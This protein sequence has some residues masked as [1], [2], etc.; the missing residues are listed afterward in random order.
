MLPLRL[1]LEGFLSYRDRT[2]FDFQGARLWML[3]GANGAGKSTVFDALRFALYGTHRAGK[4]NA[5]SLVH[6]ESQKL[7]VEADLQIGENVFRLVRTV[8][9]NTARATWQVRQK[10]ADN[11]EDVPETAMKSDYERWIAANI[12]LS[13]EAF[14]A[15]VYLSQGKSDAILNPDP[16][17][18]F[19]LLSQLVDLRVYEGWHA[20][21]LEKRVASRAAWTEARRRWEL[22]PLP[23][24]DELEQ[25]RAKASEQATLA[26]QL[27]TRARELELLQNDAL[28]WTNWRDARAKLLDSAAT[29]RALLGDEATIER[30]FA[31]LQMLE[32]LG[33]TLQ[34]FVSLAEGAGELR[35]QISDGRAQSGEAEEGFTRAQTAHEQARDAASQEDNRARKT[36]ESAMTL[37]L[38]RAQLAP[39]EDELGRWQTLRDE[40]GALSQSLA[41]LSE[42]DTS[43]GAIASL[44]SARDEAQGAARALPV[45]RRFAQSRARL[46]EA[47][48][49]LLQIARRAD[50]LD[51]QITQAKTRRAEA[52]RALA[53]AELGFERAREN[54]AKAQARFDAART[55]KSD[56][57]RVEGEARCHFCGQELSPEHAHAE[58]TRLQSEWEQAQEELKRAQVED[59]TA[60]FART[61]AQ[62]GVT[63]ASEAIANLERESVSSNS[64][65]TLHVGRRDDALVSARGAWDELAQTRRA[66]W[67]S[68]SFETSLESPRP[69]ASDFETWEELA[70]SL[71][72]RE[73]ALSKAAQMQSEAARLQLE[74]A[75][76]ERDLAPLHA[77][78]N[79]D[80]ERQWRARWNVVA[81]ELVAARIERDMGHSD[82]QVRERALKA[83]VTSLSLARTKRDG[84]AAK[85][86]PLAGE[87]AALHRQLGGLW[88][89]IREA[90]RTAGDSEDESEIPLLKQAGLAPSSNRVSLSGLEEG[91]SPATSMAVF[92]KHVLVPIE[93]P[94]EREFDAADSALL[95]GLRACAA[96]WRQE[97]ARLRE[98]NIAARHEALSQAREALGRIEGEVAF[99]SRAMDEVP[100][101]AKCSPQE[102]ERERTQTRQALEDATQRERES[103][104]RAARLGQQSEERAHLENEMFEREREFK[105]WEELELL[106]GP[107]QLQRHLLCEAERGI[108]R[109]ANAVLEAIS[110][111]S[112]RL[113]TRVESDEAGA[114][115]PQVLDVLCTH[116]SGGSAS[117]PISPAFL[118]GSQRFR[119]AVALALGIGRTAA[120]GV[121]A[122][123]NG[124]ARAETILIDEGFG[125]LDQAG[126]DEMRDELRAL[127]RELGRII[128]VSHQEDFA[129]GFPARFDISMEA[130][131]SRARRLVQ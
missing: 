34:S 40:R 74:I 37:E 8:G 16:E 86:G 27:A 5:E 71:P 50:E 130:G 62:D 93:F 111:G 28:R 117:P 25:A 49:G 102:L 31:R 14:C 129:A 103:R 75:R 54:Q 104:E 106:L 113:E 9:R 59:A 77:K 65:A 55:A 84:L 115:T 114:K 64:D 67:E 51:A 81:A 85:L 61:G 36:A 69:D 20:A 43:E 63:K 33:P 15:A 100:D 10:V 21:A 112:L 79:D 131:V 121:S 32:R 99:L 11:W 126:R 94:I 38:E 19:D 73:T 39:G 82:L 29:K 56:F 24:A 80:K 91:V 109:E 47:D 12:G 128:L 3:S 87:A 92:K 120:R 60:L 108:V 98:E 116:L 72:A 1:C 17:A 48:A 123:A 30:E 2:E 90:L 122:G 23:D 57:A 41:T 107:R 22:S 88:P 6:H 45:W 68:D 4:Q 119:V 95:D 46:N 118:S 58:H 66:L 125:S 42:T 70:A 53:K 83:C 127:G 18:R 76:I 105:R 13:D 97:Q 44:Q 26:Q 89:S 101:A 7:M 110:G 124:A 96:T 78:W 52:A 35:R